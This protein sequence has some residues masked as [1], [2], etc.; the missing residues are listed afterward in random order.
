MLG[1][2]L[3]EPVGSGHLAAAVPTDHQHPKHCLSSAM[4]FKHKSSSVPQLDKL[5][6][7]RNTLYFDKPEIW[8]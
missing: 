4:L 1:G 5:E 7:W 3:R 2:N 6:E 8:T